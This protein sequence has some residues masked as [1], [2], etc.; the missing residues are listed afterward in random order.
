[1][2]TR[3]ATTRSPWIGLV[4]AV[5]GV[6]LTTVGI[7]GLREVVPAVSTGVV[8]L[9]V[10]LL[11]SSYWGLALGLATSVAST[12]A[13][14]FFHI[15]PTGRFTIADPQ[16]WVAL[17]VY[18][19]VA[20]VVSAFANDARTRQEQALRGRREADLSAALAGVLLGA[21]ADSLTTAAR[22]VD[23]ALD[24]DGV[25]LETG[26]EAG[27]ERMLSLPLVADG[28]RVGTVL[29][30]RGTPDAA[31]ARL[32]EAIV[33]AL[34]ALMAAR[35]RRARLEDQVVE[36]RALRRGDVLK[37][38]LLRAVSHDLRSPLTAIAAAAGG[39]DSP[40]LSQA[41]RSE[42]RDVVERE[43]ERLTRLVDDLLDLSRL[44]AGSAD[45][46]TAEASIDEVI[47]AAA[48]SPRVRGA[49][50]DIDLDPALPPVSADPA[51]LER[52]LAN[53][54][55]NCVRYSDGKPVTVRAHAQP[56]RLIVRISDH[57]PGIAKQDLERIFEPFYR[58]DEARGAG[59]GLG[60]AIARGFV[61][62][63]GG[64]LKAQSLP[65]QGTSFIMDLPIERRQSPS[66][67]P[68][69]AAKERR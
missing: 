27:D 38:T 12:L 26:W 50:L 19:A 62:A 67:A 42:I 36:S 11:V 7:Y 44:E 25:Q 46:A 29:V 54:L 13:F 39:I 63:N 23:A 16:N 33:P 1:M 51:Q 64:R 28:E 66:A 43:T 34:A 47:G 4:V 52:A 58:A 10:V 22:Q 15:P 57:G 61:E 8:Y 41:Q 65:G 30:P 55:E 60:L 9:L 2:L 31:I 32:R 48:A 49:V 17:G 18:F 24:I 20:L 5:A 3:Q 21:E 6:A 59:S 40:T 68:A 37:T 69:A 45:P 14:N 56:K 35:R 53:L